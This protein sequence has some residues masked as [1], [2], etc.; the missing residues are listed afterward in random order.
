MSWNA[1]Q[2]CIHV[3]I[4]TY[5]H[6][7]TRRLKTVQLCGVYLVSFNGNIFMHEYIHTF[8]HTC[9]HHSFIHTGLENDLDKYS[10][11]SKNQK[12]IQKPVVVMYS[13]KY[14]H[15]LIA[16][17]CQGLMPRLQNLPLPQRFKITKMVLY[18]YM[19]VCMFEYRRPQQC[20]QTFNFMYVC[21]YVCMYAS[22]ITNYCISFS[23]RAHSDSLDNGNFF[24]IPSSCPSIHTYIHI[25]IHAFLHISVYKCMHTYICLSCSHF[26]CKE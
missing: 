17:H 13:Y 23:G 25:C 19:Y 26:H 15:T 1:S 14:I 5:I 8:I 12:G 6:I 20:Q 18:V 24:G 4:Y 21:I 10:S 2:V 22:D 7:H 16:L 11:P 9:N 3:H